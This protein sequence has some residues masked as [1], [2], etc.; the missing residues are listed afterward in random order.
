ME[1]ARAIREGI[2]E[3]ISNASVVIKPLADGGEGTVA[4]FV[5]GIGAKKVELD[6]TGPLGKIVRCF[7]GVI[8]ESGT[9]IIEIAAAAGLT[10]VPDSLKNPLNTTSYGV[11]EII[12]DALNRG[13]RKFIV[14]IGGS[15]TNDCGIGMLKALGFT[16]LDKKRR[17]V[18]GFGRDV[19]KIEAISSLRADPRLQECDFRIACDVNNPLYGEKGAAVV[20]GPQK[21]ATEEIIQ[22]LDKGL[23]HFS[24]VVEKEYGLDLAKIPGAGAAGGLGYAF[25]AFLGGRLEPGISLI[26]DMVGLEPELADADIVITGEGKLDFQTSMGKAPV[27]V[28]K[29]AKKYHC[30]VIAFAGAVTPEAEECNKEGIDAYFPIIQRPMK[31]AEA[32]EKE[33]A[34]LNLKATVKQVFRLVNCYNDN[35]VK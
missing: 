20:F 29:M 21:G 8:E 3:T 17:E 15:A 10:Q 34:Y 16:F 22:E 23:F 6:V 14:G 28:A 4:T 5:E 24:Q 9:A 1:A 30:K 13:L 19:A 35:A 2:R 7:Y 32:M 11:G 12:K 25:S 27:G 31:A 33:T 26:L 18:E